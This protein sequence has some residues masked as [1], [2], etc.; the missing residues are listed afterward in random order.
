VRL[1]IL[2]FFVVDVLSNIFVF[3]FVFFAIPTTS[4]AGGGGGEFYQGGY[5][6][7]LIDHSGYLSAQTPIRK[8]SFDHHLHR[9]PIL[10]P[11]HKFKFMREKKSIFLPIIV[12]N[13]YS[14]RFFL[15][16]RLI[17]RKPVITDTIINNIK[18]NSYMINH[19]ILDIIA[20]FQSIYFFGY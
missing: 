5:L 19:N 4:I 3:G 15:R 12:T 1:T 7:D 9:F 20:F 18:I 6:Y 16:K 2:F 17:T 14:G 11:S 13:N 10:P 8:L